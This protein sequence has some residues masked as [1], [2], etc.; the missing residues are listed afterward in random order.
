MAQADIKSA[1]LGGHRAQTLAALPPDA[2]VTTRE[3]AALCGFRTSSA[4]R[5]AHLEGR[6]YPV[7]RRG[8]RGTHVWLV[9]DLVRFMRGL[10]PVPTEPP[11]P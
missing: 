9:V 2:A 5:K 4:L 1:E 11:A 6:I 7:G 10:P 3:A 8:G